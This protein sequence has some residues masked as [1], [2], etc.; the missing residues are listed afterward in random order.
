MA[1]T[2]ATLIADHPEFTA[3]AEARVTAHIAK[4][5][6]RVARTQWGVK[7]DMGVTELACHLLKKAADMESGAAEKGFITAAQVGEVSASY[8]NP[9]SNFNASYTDSDLGTTS[10]GR[11]FLTLRSELIASRVT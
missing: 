2:R 9:Q 8:S 6:L 3:V 4:A 11:A 1:V 7:A 10:Y 5:E